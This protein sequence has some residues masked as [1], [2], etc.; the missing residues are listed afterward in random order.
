MSV[1]T[2]FELAVLGYFFSTFRSPDAARQIPSFGIIVS[3]LIELKSRLFLSNGVATELLSNPETQMRLAASVDS[4]SSAASMTPFAI[5]SLA[6]IT[7]VMVE[8]TR[9][10]GMLRDFAVSSSQSARN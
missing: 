4:I 1:F 7:A 10:R 3:W 5:R 9:K 2:S 6:A 8:S